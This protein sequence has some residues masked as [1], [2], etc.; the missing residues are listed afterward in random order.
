MKKLLLCSVMSFAFVP[1]AFADQHAE[2]AVDQKAKEMVKETITTIETQTGVVPTKDGEAVVTSETVEAV[3]KVVM[4]KAPEVDVEAEAAPAVEVVEE[5]AEA[6][7]YTHSAWGYG[8]ANGA[9]KWASLD[10]GFAACGSGEKQSPINI[11]KFL[12][13][14]LPDITPAYQDA[15]LSVVNNGHSVQVKYAKGSG[16]SADSIDY[17]LLQFDFHTPSE[18]YLDGAPYPMEAHFIHQNAQGGFGIIAVMMKIGAHNPTIEGIWQNV[19]AAGAVK[20]VEGVSV[21]A[22]SLLPENLDY[23]RYEGSLTTP[24]C[25][26]GVTWFVMKEPIELSENQLKAFQSVFPVNARPVQ[27]LNDRVVTGD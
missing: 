5:K 14:D 22:A 6:P 8:A 15:P 16:F 25:S 19:P 9:H 24:P 17:G 21:N 4:E 7:V 1:F 26:E 11:D 23:Y 27:P 13:E 20:D 12:Q 2:H 18:H 3:E 10:A